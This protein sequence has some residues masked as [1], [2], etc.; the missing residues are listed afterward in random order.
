MKGLWIASGGLL[1]I[2]IAASLRVI[3]NA[4]R[5]RMQLTPVSDQWLA[6]QKRNQGQR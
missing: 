4:K 6:D 2:C 3:L 5:P 1:L